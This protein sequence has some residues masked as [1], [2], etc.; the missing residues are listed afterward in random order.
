MKQVV[1]YP[2]SR[3]RTMIRCWK[4]ISST[5]EPRRHRSPSRGYISFLVAVLSWFLVVHC[6]AQQRGFRIDDLI[7]HE[8]V[9]SAAIS[10][11]GQWLVYVRRGQPRVPIDQVQSVWLVSIVGGNSREIG[12]A[13]R[14]EHV[15]GVVRPTV[16]ALQCYQLKEQLPL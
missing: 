4:D 10:P 13:G 6:Q 1:C 5:L 3:F 2:G 12:V 14:L 7:R 15:P 11:D 9:G 8:R 16:R